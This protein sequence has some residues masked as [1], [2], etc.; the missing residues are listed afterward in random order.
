MIGHDG[1]IRVV[2]AF[3]LE[4]LA[5]CFGEAGKGL[6]R[7]AALVLADLDAHLKSHAKLEAWQPILQGVHKGSIYTSQDTNI[8]VIARQALH[9]MASFS[10]LR[11]AK[12]LDDNEDDAP[13]REWRRRIRE[14]VGEANPS[15]RGRFDQSVEISL[16]LSLKVGFAGNRLAANFSRINPANITQSLQ[17]AKSRM[18]DLDQVRE[19]VGEIGFQYHELILQQ[20]PLDQSTLSATQKLGVK[21]GL[22]QLEGFCAKH[23]IELMGCESPEDAARYICMRESA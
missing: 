16:G 1:D 2:N 14:L 9:N 10:A 13:T 19:Y 5:K 20:P 8:E 23:G 7:T 22:L 11:A 15:L 4:L 21:N 12:E 6:Y 3:T 18:V 17:H